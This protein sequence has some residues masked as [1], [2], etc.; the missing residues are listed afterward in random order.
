MKRACIVS[1]CL[2]VG[3]GANAQNA[4]AIDS[5]ILSYKQNAGNR[6]ALREIVNYYRTENLDSLRHYSNQLTELAGGNKELV[7]EVLLTRVN[8]FILFN[9]YD[10][11]ASLLQQLKLDESA[12]P[13]IRVGHIMATGRI[14]FFNQQYDKA[15]ENFYNA[16]Q[17]IKDND[18][19]ELLPEAYADIA[20]VLRQN[21]DLENCARY[22]ALALAGAT[23]M[24]NAELQV[25]VCYALCR[26]Y[27]GGISVDLDSSVYYGELG[28]EIARKAGYNYGYATM[29]DIVTAPIIR[30]GQYRKGIQMAKEARR[31]IEKYNF[32]QRSLYYQILNE[33]FAYERLGVYDSAMLRMTEGATLRP[34]GIDHHRLKYLIHKSKGEYNQALQAY[35]LYKTKYD[36]IVSGRNSASLSSLQARLEANI[37]EQEVARLTQTAEVQALQLSQQRYFLGGLAILII[38]LLGGAVLIYRQRQIKQQQALTNM[39]L[40]ET[41]KRLA[42][43]QQYR[44]S[45]LKALRS[46]MNPHFIFNALNSIQE[47]IMMNEKKLAGKFLGKFADLMR[48]YLHHSQI[49]QITVAEEIEAL[50]LYLE[51]EK[52]RFEDTLSYQIQVDEHLDPGLITIPTFLIQPYVENAIKHGLL[53]KNTDRELSVAFHYHPDHQVLEC[54]IVDNGIGRKKSGEINILRNPDHQ[55]FGMSATK[56]RLELLN[57]NNKDRPIG[58]TVYDLHNN[59]GEA[60]GTKVVLSI[61]ILEFVS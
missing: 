27:N 35:E 32:P 20:S 15:L 48:I 39:E 52:L 42:L 13:L 1:I 11:A 28:M 55:S 26:I 31:Y 57:F 54:E 46:Q 17:Q 23:A 19:T 47:Y 8:A 14:L 18:L 58:E 16:R 7:N 3:F 43:E 22:Y 9:H 37:N 50:T 33:G 30:Q 6:Q 40:E 49:K 61:P 56:N 36:S 45:E 44:A 60:I 59:N 34:T 25:R 2:L 4:V 5:L 10:S 38:L 29:V 24:N 12:S 21:N 41:R 51:L 53:H